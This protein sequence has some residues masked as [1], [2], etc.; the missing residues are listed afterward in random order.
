MFS[1]MLSQA[2]F[3]S[4]SSRSQ[5][6]L[7]SRILVKLRVFSMKIFAEF[8]GTQMFITGLTTAR[9]FHPILSQINSIDALPNFFCNIHFNIIH[10]AKPRPSKL[11][12]PFTSPPK[13]C[14]HTSSPHTWHF[15]RPFHQPSTYVTFVEAH[16]FAIFSSPLSPPP[17]Y[18]QITSS[19][20]YSQTPSANTNFLQTNP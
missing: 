8:C 19:A 13:P 16:H 1:S 6:T 9:H 11:S 18:A 17:S 14:A 15:P 2:L 4:S 7:W 10:T 12:F 5:L 3:M 20:P